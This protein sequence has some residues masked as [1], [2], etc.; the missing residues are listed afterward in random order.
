VARR[1][2]VT[3][4]LAAV[5]MVA[6]G[7][8]GDTS[9]AGGCRLVVQGDPA[10][11]IG[12]LQLPCDGWMFTPD[13][14]FAMLDGV[15]EYDDGSGTSATWLLGGSPTGTGYAQLT[16]ARPSDGAVPGSYDGSTST[17]GGST[18]FLSMPSGPGTFS[19]GAETYNTGRGAISLRLQA[20]RPVPLGDCPAPGPSAFVSCGRVSGTIHASLLSNNASSPGTVTLDWSF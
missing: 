20:R 9:G 1:D 3:P 8:S 15:Y 7:G 4:L 10:S 13:H 14:A 5:A 12:R 19:W 2:G 6:C 11:G 17:S 18:T 16:F